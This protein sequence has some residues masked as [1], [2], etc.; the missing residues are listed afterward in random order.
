MADSLAIPSEGAAELRR[1]PPGMGLL[2]LYGS[3]A[4]VDA[5]VQVAL[6]TFLFYYLTAV[7]GLSN[8]LAGLSLF[9]ALVFDAVIDPMVGS[10]SDNSVSRWGRR[11]PFMLVSAFPMAVALGLLFSIPTAFS[12]WAL[13]AYVTVVSIALRM[14]HSFYVLP[15]TALGAEL[16]DDYAARTNVVASRFLFQFVGTSAGLSVGLMGFLRGPQ[17]LM[18]RSAYAPFGWV[19][20]GL[21][22]ASA[23][24]AIFGTRSA[25]SRLHRVAPAEGAFATRLVRDVREIFRN[26]SF[27]FLFL[28]LVV[29]FTGAGTV[30]TLNLHALTFFWKAPANVILAVQLASPLG[31][32]IGVPV[33]VFIANRLEKR[34]VVFAC[35]LVLVAYHASVPM[36]QVAG[37]LPAPGPVLWAILIGVSLFLG[38]VVGCAGIG[39]QSMMADAADEHESLFGTRRE[40]LYYAGLNF[41]AKAATGL[42][43]LIAGLGLD[44]I[45]FPTNLAARGGAN[46]HIA[47]PILHHLG[48][49]IGPLIAVIYAISAAVF[50]GYRLDRPRY[51]KI[52]AILEERRKAAQ[53]SAAAELV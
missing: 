34:I 50:L 7:C 51:A 11:H 27:V 13:F 9:V 36:L 48:L 45:G 2:A 32:L 10:I 6:A 47:T 43:A 22:I 44:L 14:S 42:G 25:I 20:G 41:S 29:L 3:G 24:T 33:S 4:I 26:R 21:I 15:Y 46:L 38:A 52:Q 39:F 30:A 12:A 35:I 28:T 23:L 53:T 16:T 8:S 1:K 49:I 40:G 18:H 37:W 31:L 17:G 19:C 5:V